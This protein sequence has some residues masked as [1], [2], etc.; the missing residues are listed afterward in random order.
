MRLTT[1]NWKMTIVIVSAYFNDSQCLVPDH[2]NYCQ[3]TTKMEEG[4]ITGYHMLQNFTI[5]DAAEFKDRS[6]KKKEKDQ[7]K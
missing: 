7:V 3:C 2:I 6:G 4:S 1:W 5:S